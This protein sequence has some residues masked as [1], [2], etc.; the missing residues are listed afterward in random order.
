MARPDVQ[1][2]FA[3]EGAEV[4]RMG[5]AEFGAF[6]VRETSKWARVVKEGKI[7]PE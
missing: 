2:Q 3:A 6:M 5:S 4:V 7:K 1:K